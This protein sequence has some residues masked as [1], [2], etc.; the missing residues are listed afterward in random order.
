MKNLLLVLNTF[1]LFDGRT[2]TTLVSAAPHESIGGLLRGS[3]GDP[4]AQG[5]RELAEPYTV[6]C[7]NPNFRRA[8]TGCQDENGDFFSTMIVSADEKHEVRCCSDSV[9]PYFG[10]VTSEKP[11]F[12][13]VYA[14][15]KLPTL[16]PYTLGGPAG[17]LQCY[18]NVTYSEAVD[19]CTNSYARLCTVDEI[20]DTC[21]VGTGCQFDNEF[22]WTCQGNTEDCGY[23]E[24]EDDF[25]LVACGNPN[26]RKA[27]TG[28]QDENGNFFDTYRASNEEK[29]EVRCCS[30]SVL[31]YFGPVTSEKP[32]F[33]EVYAVSRLPTSKP[34]SLGGSTG[35]LQCY[36]NVTYSEAVEICE[37]S[38]ARLCTAEEILKTCT[39]G[40]GC[41]FDNEWIW[42]STRACQNEA[43]CEA[44]GRF[45][46]FVGC[47][48]GQNDRALKVGSPYSISE[49]TDLCESAGYAFSSLTKGSF[50]Y[51]GDGKSKNF[52]KTN[53]DKCSRNCKKGPGKC[54]AGDAFSVFRTGV[55]P[56]DEDNYETEYIGCFSAAEP[57][58]RQYS[59][60]DLG[61]GYSINSCVKECSDNDYALAF[62][63]NGDSCSC[64]NVKLEKTSNSCNV[65]CTEGKGFCG[66][67]SI[68]GYS[69]YNTCNSKKGYESQLKC[70]G[71]IG[72]WYGDPHFLTFDKLQYNCQGLGLFT[73]LECKDYLV[74]SLFKP[75]GVEGSRASVTDGVVAKFMDFPSVQV[76]FPQ[77]ESPLAL[78][79]RGTL[80][81]HI[82][83]DGVLQDARNT[84]TI[85]VPEAPGLEISSRQNVIAIQFP[86]DGPSL[87]I[88]VGGGASGNGVMS[89]YACVP[90]DFEETCN[91]LLG[92]ANGAKD[93]EW[94]ERDGTTIFPRPENYKREG[95]YNY[96]TTHWCVESEE[97]SIF[98]L[99]GDKTF[100]DLYG[101]SYEY[102]GDIDTDNL[103]EEIVQ[104]C[105]DLE[106]G[107]VEA[108]LEDEAEAFANG[109]GTVID[110]LVENQQEERAVQGCADCED[111]T[112]PSECTE[113]VKLLKKVGSGFERWPIRILRQDITNVTV[114]IVSPIVE[115]KE[116]SEIFVQYP[117]VYHFDPNT[118][119]Q[120]SDVDIEFKEEIVLQ[121]NPHTKVALLNFYAFD[122][123]EYHLPR[124]NATVPECCHPDDEAVE[125]PGVRYA[126]H[127][128]CESRCEAT[129]M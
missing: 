16:E 91:G 18:D 70:T 101:C 73:V 119:V 126:F 49:C 128:A 84:T 72:S 63:N 51:C 115:D 29:H 71:S 23:S 41:R 45:D 122:E 17:G 106:A 62:L 113:D 78:L 19:I 3:D 34:Y 26:S 102:P 105:N 95:G 25:H 88:R 58:P 74:Q 99:G 50:C 69:V 76:N 65:P 90:S 12:C 4:L 37:N 125:H 35:G 28:C 60:D 1:V 13:G 98:T 54:G 33:C 11:D 66:G 127:V 121:C 61:S 39:K 53:T 43:E 129:E 56:T 77:F 6:A 111:V 20:L 117:Q 93:D 79:V 9:L 120:F 112:P 86:E 2:I 107:L 40:T 27:A 109:E 22:I 42:T 110:D 118:C 103:P 85:S 59:I 36:D 81:V 82:F 83:V 64:G 7:G 8:A 116:V 114:Q 38:F 10:P 89:V 44:E 48:S 97:D 5:K 31:P 87:K 123:C 100:E 46:E 68:T 124:D 52:R 94:M 15:S 47:F 32:D 14:V 108:C 55:A 92:T 80:P 57:T 96:C 21:T 67:T 30:D 75:R 24:P 104:Q